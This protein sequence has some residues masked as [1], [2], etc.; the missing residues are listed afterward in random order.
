MKKEKPYG[1]FKMTIMK[2]TVLFL[3]LIT[4][5][6]VGISQVKF[7]LRGGALL[8]GLN[9][10]T[11]NPNISTENILSYQAGIQ[12]N[13]GFGGL[14]G[15]STG[16]LYSAKG[17]EIDSAAAN[18]ELK[19]NYID[20]PLLLEAKFGGKNTNVFIEGGMTLSFAL[21]GTFDDGINSKEDIKF[22]EDP[23]EINL[24][25]Y[26]LSVG[27]GVNLDGFRLGLNYNL[28][29]NNLSNRSTYELK[30]KNVVLYAVLFLN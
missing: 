14:L 2:K 8:S 9:Y 30:N 4:M 17:S 23:D 7:G 12:I 27:A 5:A 28:G 16:V 24:L 15:F 21:N 6:Q 20:V 1:T 29:L 22:G 11:P 3:F 19:I 18:G 25:D 13:S 26:G 10:D